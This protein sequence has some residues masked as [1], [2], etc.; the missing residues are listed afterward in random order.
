VKKN[1]RFRPAGG[2][3]RCHV[4]YHVTRVSYTGYAVGLQ[5][6]RLTR[7]KPDAPQTISASKR[8]TASRVFITSDQHS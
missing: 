3:R 2:D 4:G 1:V 7:W 5:T 6:G 8:V